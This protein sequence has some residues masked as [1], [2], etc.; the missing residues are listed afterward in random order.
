VDRDR[1]RRWPHP[2]PATEGLRM[3]TPGPPTAAAVPGGKIAAAFPP[4]RGP[5]HR[6][7]AAA[8]PQGQVAT[9]SASMAWRRWRHSRRRFVATLPLNKRCPA[10][11]HQG[12]GPQ[13]GQS[14][15]RGDV[16]A[17][18][19]SA[20]VCGLR[21][22]GRSRPDHG[23]F[24]QRRWGRLRHMLTRRDLETQVVRIRIIGA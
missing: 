11:P 13:G 1:E 9:K 22:S 20:P 10:E 17:I 12:A 3:A 6:E 2:S 21:N 23:G 7:P 8:A 19:G 5:G 4:F 15:T 16:D 24:Y 18:A 14:A